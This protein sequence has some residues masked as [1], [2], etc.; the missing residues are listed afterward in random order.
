MYIDTGSLTVDRWIARLPWP[1]RRVVAAIGIILFLLPIVLA[2][3]ELGTEMFPI[4]LS[5]DGRHM[6]FF[7]LMITY[8]LAVMGPL[9]QTRDGVAQALRPLVQV[10]EDTFVSVVDRACRVNPIGE[11]IAFGVGVAFS[12]G[13]E[14]RYEGSPEY[15]I[16]VPYVYL[17]GLIL[18]G[19]LGWSIYGAINVTRL[20]NELLRLPVHIDIFDIEA[21]EPIGRQSLY[22]ALTFIGATILSL[23]FIVS[24]DNLRE[25]LSL[26]NI[27]I[28]GILIFLT[29]TVFF[30]NMRRTHSLLTAAK[31]Q[32]IKLAEERLARA[33]HI[34]QDL[35]SKDQDTFPVAMEMNALAIGKQELKLTRTWPFDTEMLR[36][37]FLSILT[38]IAIGLARVVAPLFMN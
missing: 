22:L 38:P 11:L 17:A 32:Q 37:L 18:F 35:I 33:Y 30:L 20:T 14:G 4:L 26:E 23:F 5:K 29:I 13:I 36:T 15:P 19:T 27:I 7:P 34:L 28:Y 3:L 2:Y 31:R 24:P 12:F 6:F 25:F 10:D 21:L 1:R 9:Q 8:L 16:L